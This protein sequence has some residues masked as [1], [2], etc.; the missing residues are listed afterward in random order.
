MDDLWHLKWG[1]DDAAIFDVS[2]EYLGNRSLTAEVHCFWEAGRIIAQYEEDIRQ[3][4]THKWE[5]GCLQDASIRRLE[6]ANMLERLDRAQVEQHM[7]A[8]KRTDATVHRG[9]C[10]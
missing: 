9:H 8:V 7:R 3:L 2:L 1:S 4:E 10:L 5:A 6:S